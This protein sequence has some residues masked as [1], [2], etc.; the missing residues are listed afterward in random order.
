[1]KRT[2]RLGAALL[3]GAALLGL[4]AT[5]AA[6]AP[7]PQPPVLKI[8]PLGDSITE[9]ANSSDGAGYRGPLW[10]LMAGQSRYTPD[11]VG[12]GKQGP[13]ADPD[14]EGHS[15]EKIEFALQNIDRWQAV[16]NPDVVLLHMGINNLRD[17]VTDPDPAVTANKLSQLVDRLQF[18]RPGVTV[19]V[20]GLL[21]DTI[22]QEERTAAFNAV[23]RQQVASRQ[24][25][26]QR[27]RFVEPPKMALPGQP[28]GEFVDGLHP[29]DT[30]HVKLAGAYY[31]ALEQAVTDGW[32]KRTPR[33]GN[34][35]GGANRV[36]WA[37]WDGDGRQ[38]RFTV[39]DNGQVDVKLN[40]GGESGGQTLVRVAGG[41]TT[42]RSRARFADWDGDGKADYLLVN[43]NGSIVVYLN[44]GGD[45]GGGWQAAGQVAS[46]LTTTQDKVRFSDFDGD[47]RTDYGVFSDNGAL[48]VYANR[49]GDTGGGWQGLGQVT[50]GATSDRSRV[51][52]SDLD[53]DGR[54]DYLV[55]A[56]NGSVSGYWNRGGDNRGGWQWAGQLASGLTS[57]KDKVHFADISGDARADYIV[58]GSGDTA[59]AYAFNGGDPL[60]N[61]WTSL[62]TVG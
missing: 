39:A 4:G 3:T 55:I 58:A 1:M 23:A 16:T 9:G 11:F 33:S 41:L 8:M 47:G 2:T 10:K 26:G 37:D 56:A 28:N 49:G 60:P 22:G 43:P 15:G 24:A 5:P 7:Q 53:G 18:N 20:L 31:G 13:F 44:R 21:T 61:G 57:D 62:G 6:A 52:L 17:R 30:G 27:V 25:A 14:H 59:T 12:S 50:S 34:E 29:N 38:D 51:R 32:T 19:I 48:T 45:V 40:A 46:G 54:A 42:D 35:S 36:R